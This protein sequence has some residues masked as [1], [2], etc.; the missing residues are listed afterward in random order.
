MSWRKYRYPL[1]N[2][3][4]GAIRD[5]NLIKEGDKIAVGLSGGK[6][7]VILLYALNILKNILPIKFELQAIYLDLGWDMD[8]TPMEE[9]CK[10]LNIP[11]HI[12][13][14]QIGQ[15]VFVE[16]KEKNPCSLCARMRRGAL[17]SKAKELGCNK[18]ALGHH[19]DDA[20][21]TLFMNMTYEGRIGS[22]LPLTYLDRKDITVIRPLVYVNEKDIQEIIKDAN[23]PTVR[24]RC[25]KDGYSTRLIV[26]EFISDLELVNPNVKDRMLSALFNFNED[27]FWKITK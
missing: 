19:R 15:I 25:P 17:H 26:K 14:T 8:L 10:Q 4:K 5:F 13:F 24:N 23:L 7:S 3:V 18:V 2:K 6:D 12:E 27:D 1:F 16:R 9:F 22:F 21:E 11:F 20:I